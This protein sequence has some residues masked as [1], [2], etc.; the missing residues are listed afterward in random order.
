MSTKKVA[1]ILSI[2][3]G[4]IRGIVPASII[5][6]L[7]AILK[8]PIMSH[9]HMVAG[10]STGGILACGL[11]IKKP[12]SGQELVEF[13]QQKGGQIFEAPSAGALTGL[14]G[15]LYSAEG[16]EKVL[17]G[18]L[19][20]NLSDVKNDLLV[21]SY[22][23]ES[24]NPFIFKSWQARAIESLKSEIPNF[25]FPIKS[26]ARATSAAPT[27]FKPARIT[28]LAGESFA[29]IDGG[30]YANNPA[31][32]AYAA[33]TRLYPLAD[34]YQILSLGTGE[35]KVPFLYDDAV[36]WG[37]VGWARPLLD[38]M[39]SGV[40]ETISYELAQL[41]PTV[42]QCRLQTKLQNGSENMDDV[43]PANLKA[44]LEDTKKTISDNQTLIDDLITRLRKEPL[45]SR[46]LLGYP[47]EKVS[48]VIR[49]PKVATIPT[50][51]KNPVGGIVAGAATGGAIGLAVG[52]PVGAVIGAGLGA[53]GVKIVPD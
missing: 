2:D 38:V 23:I 7:E 50:I 51:I 14:A 44:L 52:G 31:M 47:G 12:L 40:S 18:I 34:E 37:L 45:T 53:F 21:T 15:E 48:G 17:E 4:G 13:Y 46:A 36:N 16:L 43:S 3:G 29:L 11:N 30:V 28:N 10:T 1:R 5:A 19:P 42:S 6:A 22:D 25:D 33:A 9:F 35:L 39:F 27:Y 8:T 20:G 26:V 32:C 41:Q 49:K 24:R